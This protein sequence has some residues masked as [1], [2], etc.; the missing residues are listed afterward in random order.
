MASLNSVLALS[1]MNGSK[2]SEAAL[3]EGEW[4]I[5]E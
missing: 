3:F 5:R 1:A 4:L 2:T